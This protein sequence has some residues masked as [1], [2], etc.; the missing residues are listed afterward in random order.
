[1][2]GKETS[3]S[4]L[5]HFDGYLMIIVV[6]NDSRIGHDMDIPARSGSTCQS[7]Q[8]K[9]NH[10]RHQL[11]SPCPYSCPSPSPALILLGELDYIC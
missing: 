7:H 2:L 10:H 4:W 6:K 3:V 9:K 5:H 8:Q 1:M 11:A